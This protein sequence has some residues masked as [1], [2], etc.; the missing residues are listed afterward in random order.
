[1]AMLMTQKLFSLPLIVALTV[2]GVVF[3]ADRTVDAATFEASRPEPCA[4]GYVYTQ[5]IVTSTP[6]QPCTGGCDGKSTP[7]EPLHEDRTIYFRCGES[8]ME[9]TE[10][11]KIEIVT[12]KRCVP[13]AKVACNDSTPRKPRGSTATEANVET[14]T[15]TTDTCN[16]TLS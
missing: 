10:M 14:L 11:C 9:D 12:R 16:F 4:P 5:H 6:M 1:M 3:L 8:M 7:Y 15:T 13:G 2:I